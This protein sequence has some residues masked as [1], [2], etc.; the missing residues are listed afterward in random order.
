[1]KESNGSRGARIPDPGIVMSGF[2]VTVTWH[3]RVV[4][5]GVAGALDIVTAPRLTRSIQDTL[6]SK[7]SSVIVDLTDVEFLASAGM[8]VLIAAHEQLEK[9]AQFLVVA[10]GPATGRPMHVAGVD[11][12]LTIH[13]TLHSA[14]EAASVR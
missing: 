14:L 1:V 12:L 10:D 7:P 13:P 11:R 9:S 4:V 8:S 6:K 3:D 5:V 2:D